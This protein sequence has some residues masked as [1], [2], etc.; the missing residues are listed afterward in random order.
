MNGSNTENSIES[1][2][3]KTNEH[4]IHL[5]LLEFQCQRLNS[6]SSMNDKSFKN[7]LDYNQLKR[8]CYQ[9]CDGF[10][11]RKILNCASRPVVCVKVWVYF[12]IIASV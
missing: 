8:G 3:I 7:H 12:T 5:N 4:S 9:E 10:E 2:K 6:K 11:T 1:L